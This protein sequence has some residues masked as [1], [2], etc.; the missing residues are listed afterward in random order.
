MG[1][2]LIVAG[3]FTMILGAMDGGALGVVALIFGALAAIVGM[4]SPVVGVVADAMDDIKDAYNLP[5]KD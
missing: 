1:K 5:K 4:L 2:I 3:G